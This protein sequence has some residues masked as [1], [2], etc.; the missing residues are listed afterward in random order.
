MID[1]F[2]AAAAE[3]LTAASP[4]NSIPEVAM[5][6]ET[7]LESSFNQSEATSGS[8]ITTWSDQKKSSPNK[9][10][11]S[12]NSVAG[13]PTY[14]NT[15][16]RIH[17]V[18]FN[19]GGFLEFDGRFLNQTDYTIVILEKRKSS[20]ANSY[21]LGSPSSGANDSILLG[22]GSDTV[23]VHKQGSNSYAQDSAIE[24]YLDS[25]EK[26][27]LSVFM[28]SATEGKKT[29]IN[30]TLASEDSTNLA[31]LSGVTTLAIGKGYVGEI[32]EIAIALRIF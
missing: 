10:V 6:L 27:R 13:C 29:Y 15:I 32:G 5:W 30:G 24:G 4:I 25:K 23:V 26:A 7:S 1:K 20:S 9:V 28:H 8:E 11:I 3:S 16:N 14:S 22:Y 17:A 18:E 21:F 19:N 31:P 2:R 12:C